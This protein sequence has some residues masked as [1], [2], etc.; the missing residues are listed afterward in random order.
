MRCS[1]RKFERVYDGRGVVKG[2]VEGVLREESR[3]KTC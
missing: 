1:M 2:K 3:L